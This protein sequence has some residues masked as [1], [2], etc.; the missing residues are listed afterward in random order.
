MADAPRGRDL[1]ELTSALYAL[2]FGFYLYADN[3]LRVDEQIHFDQIQRL[4]TGPAPLNPGLTMLPGFHAIIAAFVSVVGGAS[5]FNARLGAFALSL[6]TLAAFYALVRTLRTDDTGTRI[7]QFT[8]LPILFPQF[9]LIYTDVAAMLFVL[10]MMLA[11][12]RRHYMVAGVMGLVSCLVRQNDIIWVLFVMCWSYL[13]DNGWRWIPLRHSLER[14]WTFVATGVALVVFVVLNGGQVALGDAKAHPLGGLHLTNV[15]F[16]LF[17]AF[18]LFLPL[19]WGYRHHIAA[20]MRNRWTWVALAGLFP[21]FWFGFVNSHPYNLD[22]TDYYMRNAVLMYFT[23]SSAMKLLFF[24]PVAVA[25]VCISAVPVSIPWWLLYGFTVLVLLP[26]WLV[27]Q[28]YYLIPLALFLIAREPVG[29]WAER[30]QTLVFV[31]GSAALFVIVER[32]WMW[33]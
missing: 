32:S 12:A 26:E 13:R 5:E 8:F 10:L 28:R 3:G 24:V 20:R 27:E 15:F 31:L 25:A 7:L 17:L 14:Y 18:F 33:M 9:F 11:A 21:L 30:T 6:A 29:R 23:T 19:W 16:L 4:A 22:G 1:P 2:C